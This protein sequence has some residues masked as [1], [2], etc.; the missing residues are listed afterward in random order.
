VTQKFARIAMSTKEM[1]ALRKT[2]QHD[3]ATKCNTFEKTLAIPD[4]YKVFLQVGADPE[5]QKLRWSGV[6]CLGFLNE[7]LNCDK[8]P[9]YMGLSASS[10]GVSFTAHSGGDTARRAGDRGYLFGGERLFH[11]DRM[12]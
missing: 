7:R 3:T 4:A 10:T 11:R 1:T 8:S 6:N 2:C 12:Q 5:V 9:I